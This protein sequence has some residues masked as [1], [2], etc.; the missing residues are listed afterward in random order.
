[1]SMYDGI[2]LFNYLLF[3]RDEYADFAEYRCNTVQYSTTITDGNSGSQRMKS[4]SKELPLLLKNLALEKVFPFFIVMCDVNPFHVLRLVL[5]YG[6][7]T[8]GIF[9]RG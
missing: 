3:R 9:F 5:T 8:T 4:K 7:A 1:M 2:P 6:D